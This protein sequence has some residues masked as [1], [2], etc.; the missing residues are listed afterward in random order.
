MKRFIAILLAAPLLWACNSDDDNGGTPAPMPVSFEVTITNVSSPFPFYQSGTFNTPVGAN[1][2]GPVLP[3]SGDSYAFTFQAGTNY[4]PGAI[5]KLT[6]LTMLVASNDLF[7]APAADGIPLYDE[8]GD[9]L[10]GD[11]TD[12]IYL[13]DAGTEVNKA[14]GSTDQPGPTSDPAGSGDVEN[15]LVTLLGGTEGPIDVEIIT[16]NGP[17]TFTYPAVDE[18]VRVSISSVGTIFTVTIENLSGESSVP[19]P[20]SPGGFVV[21][22]N[23]NPLF[24]NGEAERG[25]GVEEIAEDGIITDFANYTSPET[26]LI[27]PISPGVWAVHDSGNPLF[28]DGQADYGDGLEDIAEDGDASSIGAIIESVANVSSGGTFG[29]APAGPGGSYTFTFD[30]VPGDRLSMA[31]MFV[32]SNDWIFTF[33]EEGIPLFNG[34][35]PV[36][37]DISTFVMIYD[38]GT[39]E[40]QYP[41]AGPDQ[42]I[43]QSAADT[44]APDDNSLVREVTTTPEIVPSTD[45]LL[46]VQ[47]TPQL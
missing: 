44:G 42:A 43:R 33:D 24:T 19:S 26:G 23:D 31:T 1:Q 27:N 3:G 12:L 40:D 5:P 34:S 36:S 16:D 9:P 38:V 14:P 45:A 4:L 7:I 41:G 18:L 2:P 13:W 29:S 20:L 32:Q 17:E 25:N 21:H 35:V 10:S 46:L 22:V 6:F 47:I 39:E 28:T 30:A 37:G 8:N 11:I 15:G